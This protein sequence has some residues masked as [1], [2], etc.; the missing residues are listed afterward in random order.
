VNS[1]TV[2][3]DTATIDYL[4]SRVKVGKDIDK[5]TA[6]TLNNVFDYLC[7]TREPAL[8][9]ST[10]FSILVNISTLPET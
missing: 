2:N 6:I 10:V 8:M 7:I 1:G 9:G 5:Y 4:E 3:P